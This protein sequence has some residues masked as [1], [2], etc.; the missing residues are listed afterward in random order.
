MAAL[1]DGCP[2]EM[3]NTTCFRDIMYEIQNVQALNFFVI[4]YE[5][6]EL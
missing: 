3:E 2:D 6:Q 5:A 4:N 1:L